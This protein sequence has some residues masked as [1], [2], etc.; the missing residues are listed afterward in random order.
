MHELNKRYSLCSLGNVFCNKKYKSKP[1]RLTGL[2][3]NHLKSSIAK[4]LYVPAAV[5][6]ASCHLIG[7]S[8]ETTDT[9]IKYLPSKEHGT[10]REY[11]SS[12]ITLYAQNTNTTQREILWYLQDTFSLKGMPWC[13][14]D[15]RDQ[16]VHQ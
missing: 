9:N 12:D 4:N 15:K 7:C 8:A 1:R 3:I 5:V 10:P 11:Q 13:P 16:V 14:P 6:L 2:F